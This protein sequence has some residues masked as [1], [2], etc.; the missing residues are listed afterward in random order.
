MVCLLL[1]VVVVVVEA[2]VGVEVLVVQ[3]RPDEPSKIPFLSAFEVI[4][5]PHSACAKD[6]A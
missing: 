6:E 3:I 2:V 5:V 4:H 1:E